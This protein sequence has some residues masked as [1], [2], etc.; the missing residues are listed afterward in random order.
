MKVVRITAASAAL[1]LLVGS[2]SVIADGHEEYSDDNI[3]PVEI[4]AC[5]F[6]EGMGPD[7]LNAVTAK[8]NEWMDDEEVTTYFAA[9]LYPAFSTELPFDVGWIGGWSDGNAMGSGTDMWMGEGGELGAEFDAVLDCPSHVL[10]ATMNMREPKDS[11][12]DDDDNF[13]LMFSNCSMN[14]GTS[15]EDVEAAQKKWNAHADEHGFI[16]GSWVM[17]P[18]W[19]ESADADYDF[20]FVGST[21]NYTAL[22]G[23]FQMMAEGHWRKN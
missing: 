1:M 20:K 19:G 16:G 3:I 10:F 23:N 12:D 2:G 11:D 6:E 8:W 7:D 21:P 18:V 13:V 5:S 17:W 4:F 14:E 22:G 9:H 15:F